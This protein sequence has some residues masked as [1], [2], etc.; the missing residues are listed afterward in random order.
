MAVFEKEFKNFFDIVTRL[1]LISAEE[2]KAFEPYFA[3]LSNNKLYVVL[4]DR[5]HDVNHA[6]R[7]ALYT[8]L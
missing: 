2:Q 1:N 3:E 5:K 7:C 4:Y 8:H 6:I